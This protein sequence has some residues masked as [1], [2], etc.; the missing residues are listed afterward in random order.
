VVQL[1]Y[2]AR[3]G[4][5]GDGRGLLRIDG[6]FW[7]TTSGSYSDLTS[8]A[9]GPVRALLTKDGSTVIRIQLVAGPL[10]PVPGA[11]DIGAVSAADAARY[12]LDLARTLEGRPARS[13]ILAAAIADSADVGDQFLAIARD[14]NKARELRS[15]ALTWAAR[16]A[17][18]AGSERMATSLDAIAR[19]V[20]ERQA[21]RT[22]ALSGLAGLEGSAGVSALMRLTER[23]DDPWLLGQS[24]DALSRSNDARVRP[25][26]RKLLDNKSTPEASRVKVITALGNTDG[27]VSDAAALRA[28]YPQFSERERSAAITAVA[29]IGDR[30][31]VSWM[32]DR[33]KDPAESMLLRRAAAQRAARAGAKASELATLYDAVIERT[34]R[35][36]LVDALAEDGS[37]PA[38]DKLLA[39]AQETASDA[40]VRRRAITKLGE[41][42]DPRAKDLLQTLISR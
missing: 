7:T 14:V 32:L 31:S 27:T 12:F 42:G 5:C 4:V 34:L 1:H 8:C 16:R 21:M 17:G 15:S 39:I 18:V 20:N 36:A 35:E 33:A 13:A 11:T 19:D 3:T 9:A 6:G 2:A 26:L 37:R 28:A 30:A 29:N 23:T 41:S 40:T 22:T 10:S 24:A 25:H 38:L